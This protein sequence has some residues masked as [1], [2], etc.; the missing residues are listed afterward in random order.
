M[1]EWRTSKQ[2]QDVEQS[3]SEP[4]LASE[5]PAWLT[6][7]QPIHVESSFADRTRQEAAGETSPFHDGRS[8]QPFRDPQA[9]QASLLEGLT[10]PQQQAVLHTEGPLLVL[11]AAGSGKT[12]V[13]TRRIAY[14]V[15]LGIQPWSIL[16]LTF[17]NKAAG[18]MRERVMKI[19]NPSGDP[20]ARVT[21][22][23]T[24]TTFHALCARL[25][26]RYA[27]HAGLKADYTI[28]DS[29]DQ[30]A[31]VKKAIE[32]LQLSTSNFQPRSVLG[33]ISNAKNQL[34]GPKDYADRAFDFT[35]R[36]ISKIYN[37]YEKVLRQA[38][39][40]DFDD[41]LLLTAKLLQNHVEVR[42]EL[43]QRWQY[44]LVDE[45][46]DTNKAQ[47]VIASMIAGEQAALPKAT[48][49]PASSA[50]RPPPNICV[51]GDPDQA[52]YGWRGAD[53]SNI[54]DF[55]AHYPTC[56]TITLGENF[57]STAPILKLADTLI[58]Q[59]KR[60]KHKDLFTTKAGGEKVRAV[61]CR[62]ERHE[63]ALVI[64]WLKLQR[65]EGAEAEGQALPV[66]WKDMAIFYRTNALSRVLE[67]ALRSAN[68]PYTIARGTAF[69]DR[70][71]VKNAL[72]YLRV[73]A[74]QADDV[75][76]SRIINTP[77]RGISDPTWDKIDVMAQRSSRPILTCMR[78][79][80]PLDA[81]P[82][83]VTGRAINSIQKF[84]QLIDEWSGSQTF[85]GQQLKEG[86]LAELVDRV[87]KESGLE[88]MYQKQASQSQSESDAERLDNL[89]ELVSSAREFQMEYDPA[90]DPASE[91]ASELASDLA[92]NPA[93]NS[94]SQLSADQARSGVA[95]TVPPLL[96][97]L[98]AF[99]ESVAL[100]AD[101]D[102]IDPSQGS[103]TLMTLH[104][105]KGLE[106]PVVAMVG[107]EEGL[108]PHTRAVMSAS[109]A[110]MEEER[111]L[112]FVG[113][114]RAM[115]HL[116][117][118][119]AKYRTLRGNLER[120]IPS[121]FLGEMPQSELS[122]SD[123]SDALGD[124]DDTDWNDAKASQGTSAPTRPAGGIAR[125]TAHP[126]A[127]LHGFSAGMKVRHPQ[128]GMGV[129]RSITTG[130][131]PRAI[132]EFRDAGTKTLVL[133]YAR[134][135]KL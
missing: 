53:I 16:A 18:E 63:A 129:I 116:M 68:L 127:P 97:L 13:I 46:Q 103:I 28:Y 31:L 130:A 71:E 7:S 82:L 52:I 76:L 60:R 117:L 114:T 66:S 62:D 108:M 104:A 99:L 98:R 50:T 42:R 87:L 134:L 110:E 113:V 33:A 133:E 39:A 93:I 43:Q 41:L 109:D 106:F 14:L 88:A 21:R 77:S 90:S 57:R 91:L 128:F 74:N 124:L 1:D 70:E 32:A 8:G 80:T 24:V 40:V 100:V 79:L 55:E 94:A 34:L 3:R 25:L 54:L 45:Y 120:T 132:I 125:S 20:E 35:S 17:T 44:L 47:F 19:L 123:Q 5:M 36:N 9:W 122:I 81:E 72:A 4:S 115:K 105:A 59:N 84:V 92:I 78:E 15:S 2:R 111:R 37:A 30:A 10:K 102:T 135:T 131:Q 64:D 121:R 49:K 56:T 23:L 29:G 65:S 86:S 107:L 112:C 75:S 95:N 11:A 101:A 126:R 61:L 38:N 96:A 27:E 89:S 73:V 58:Q 83:G 51:V 118:T 85:L 6:P 26:R 67:D 12:R 48:A 22:G 69:Y 119:A